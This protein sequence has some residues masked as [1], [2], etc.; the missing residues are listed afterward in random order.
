[1]AT[2]QQQPSPY[3]SQFLISQS[4]VLLS[5]DLSIAVISLTATILAVVERLHCIYFHLNFRKYPKV[6]KYWDTLNH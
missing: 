5:L 2:S 1:M 4:V 6:L 3:N